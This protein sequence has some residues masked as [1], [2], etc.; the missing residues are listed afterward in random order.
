[1]NISKNAWHYKLATNEWC[2]MMS[3]WKPARSLCPYFWYVVLSGL[4][5]F[6]KTS[7]CTIAVA[8]GIMVILEPVVTIG[9]WVLGLPLDHLV[10]PVFDADGVQAGTE[11]SFRGVN[12][13]IGGFL[14]ICV[15][16]VAAVEMG[17]HAWTWTKLKDL[18]KWGWSKVSNAEFVK[19]ERV[20]TAKK[21]INL[22]AEYV[23]AKHSK[24]CPMVSF[25]DPSDEVE[26]QEQQEPK[27]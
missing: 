27:E 20:Q 4:W 10:Q 14:W 7:L 6:V 9:M 12:L 11:P 21:E 19:T 24:V 13:I 17:L 1:M 25:V 18:C 22:A 23:K 3:E 15:A 2:G 5:G 16:I 8:Y 26:P